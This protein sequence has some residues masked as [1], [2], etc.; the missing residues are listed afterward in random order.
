MSFDISTY[1]SM[2]AASTGVPFGK[3]PLGEYEGMTD[4][5]DINQ[6]FFEETLPKL[7][8][9]EEFK[10]PD[11]VK[12]ALAEISRDL[13]PNEVQ[14]AKDALARATSNLNSQ[15]SNLQHYTQQLGICRK[16][17]DRVM[18]LNTGD[19]M[20]EGIAKVLERGLY[21]YKN[22]NRAAMYIELETTNDVVV[23]WENEENGINRE[24]NLGKFKVRYKY[25]RCEFLVMP[26]NERMLVN[27]YPHPH[28]SSNNKVCW[29]NASDTAYASL[30][31]YKPFDAFEALWII[32]NTYNPESPYVTF[33]EFARKINNTSS[34]SGGPKYL[35]GLSWLSERDY[36][37]YLSEY[38]DNQ[39]HV[40]HS[41][42]GYLVPVYADVVFDEFKALWEDGQDI[43]TY[44]RE[45]QDSGAFISV[46]YYQLKDGFLSLHEAV[47]HRL[48]H[49][50]LTPT[51]N[52]SSSLVEAT[53]NAYPP[54]AEYIEERVRAYGANNYNDDDDEDINF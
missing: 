45:G 22:V 17:L 9:G 32:L 5:R 54:T 14:R 44:I 23:K 49:P 19:I 27:G 38:S 3:I 24:L 40:R 34:S 6:K 46:D 26:L 4:K 50:R 8:Q 41:H 43:D 20:G 15:L 2:L 11:S 1:L 39:P 51:G 29:G 21:V 28:V 37:Q 10:I 42:G 53:F 31:A 7:K 25:D 30:A 48:W 47:E 35:V 18:K 12:R 16:D 52:M 36:R 33:E 13:T